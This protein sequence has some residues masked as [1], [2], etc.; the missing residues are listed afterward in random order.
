MFALSDRDGIGLGQNDPKGVGQII[1]MVTIPVSMYQTVVTNIAQ[2]NGDPAAQ[3]QAMAQLPAGLIQAVSSQA[4]GTVQV[5]LV[6]RILD[7]VKN[8]NP[9]VIL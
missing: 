1:G 9:D 2:L 3:Q 7:I 8:I 5:L 6:L 4:G